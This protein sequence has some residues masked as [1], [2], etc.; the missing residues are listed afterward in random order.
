MS[1]PKPL[2]QANRDECVCLD[3]TPILGSL[4]HWLLVWGKGHR[5]RAP[6]LKAEAGSENH[7]QMVRKFSLKRSGISFLIVCKIAPK[8]IILIYNYLNVLQLGLCPR[9]CCERSW[10]FPKP[11]VT[12][13][14]QTKL[15]FINDGAS[16]FW[17]LDFAI[18]CTFLLMRILNILFVC[19]L[20]ALWIWTKFFAH[21]H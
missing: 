14:N 7:A 2:N 17:D 20:K 9:P 4:L 8:L 10:F 19:F 16:P 1:S 3:G 13:S 12:E 6:P 5:A 15:A 11:L 21:L 18:K